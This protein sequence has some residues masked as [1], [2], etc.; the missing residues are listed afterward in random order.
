MVLYSCP[1]DTVVI[2]VLLRRTAASGDSVILVVEVADV[3][4]TR[5]SH[6]LA[7]ELPLVN[8]SRFQHLRVS[9]VT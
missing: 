8:E 1:L 2:Q 5:L 4:D 6:A 7:L 3:V 9:S